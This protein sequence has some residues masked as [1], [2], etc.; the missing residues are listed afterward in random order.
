MTDSTNQSLGAWE[1]RPQ[2]NFDVDATSVSL[3][4]RDA[5]VLTRI[6]GQSSVGELCTI[7]GLGERETLKALSRLVDHGLVLVEP[8][9]G[10]RRM[11]NLDKRAPVTRKEEKTDAP[12]FRG[13]DPKD[14][15]WLR[16]FGDMGR[17][18]GR[19]YRGSGRSRYDDMAF[20]RE[21]LKEA[22]FLPVELKKEI[23]FLYEN[24]GRVDHF[25]LLGVAPTNERKELRASFFEFSRRFHPDTVF[26]R[27]VG[28]YKLC[29][30][31]IFKRGSDVYEM[32]STNHA[33]RECYCRAV[34]ARNRLIDEEA[35]KERA[36][37]KKASLGRLK[38]NA[39]GRK[40]Q[41]RERLKKNTEA[42]S[43]G[44]QTKTVGVRIDKAKQFYDEGMTHF[45]NESFMAATNALRLAVN[46]DPKNEQYGG[47]LALAEERMWQVKADKQWK[48]GYIQESLG[49]IN[50]A[51]E[52]YLQASEVLPRPD[53][54]AHIAQLLLKYDQDLHKAE[55]HAR[56]AVQGDPKN[57]EYR[58]VLGRIYEHA[59]LPRKAFSAFEQALQIEPK[60]E[61]AKKAVKR[62]K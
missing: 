1:D 50:E 36:A 3:D 61:E 48:R 34:T 16:Q 44:N 26:R 62:L 24:L 14:V 25:E 56:K 58:L 28:P 49:H 11:I 46:Y 37:R 5:F 4:S 40:E 55:E 2:R 33:F 47:A 20:D 30:E 17:I 19:R 54:C 39:A 21:L 57:V 53:Y 6:D 23:L 29:I 10:Q 42:R 60:N 7:T 27:D 38:A 45:E 31:Q 18:S 15:E 13:V 52:A 51:I 32:L 43:A 9:E 59:K 41:L 22:D 35:S 8:V 12:A